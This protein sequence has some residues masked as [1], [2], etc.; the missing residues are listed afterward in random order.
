MNPSALSC[1]LPA[2]AALRGGLLLAPNTRLL[3]VL[4]PAGFGEDAV[5]LDALGEALEG[6]LEG[7]VI[8]NDDFG[9]PCLLNL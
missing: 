9:Q 1:S 8:A 4:S 5:L 2:L 7:F 6:G 3:V